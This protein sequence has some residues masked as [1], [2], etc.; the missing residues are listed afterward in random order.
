MI[1]KTSAK[2]TFLDNVGAM[3]RNTYDRQT[4]LDNEALLPLPA[5]RHCRRSSVDCPTN[6]RGATAYWLKHFLF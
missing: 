2:I 1:R 4:V 6:S 5:R 3:R